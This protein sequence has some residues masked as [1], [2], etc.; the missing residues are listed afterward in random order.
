M[1]LDC[2][3]QHEDLHDHGK[4]TNTCK[5]VAEGQGVGHPT[6]HAAD[7]RQ[8]TVEHIAAAL[9]INL[10]LKCLDQR[11]DVCFVEAC[12]VLV[13]DLVT[14]VNSVVCRLDDVLCRLKV[15]ALVYGGID[16]AVVKALDRHVVSARCRYQ[17]LTGIEIGVVCRDHHL[18][19][20][21]QLIRLKACA[22][23]GN[24]SGSECQRGFPG[25]AA[26]ACQQSDQQQANGH[27]QDDASRKC[28]HF[29]F[30][31]I[32]LAVKPPNLPSL[33]WD[34]APP[35]SVF[36]ARCRGIR[37]CSMEVSSG[38]SPYSSG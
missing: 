35:L 5:V 26:T 24:Q 32:V 25:S 16:L 18:C 11:V 15:H 28:S 20:R 29:R 2:K 36:A 7:A 21:K 34:F 30:H 6:Q 3:G 22:L 14:V 23:L 37:H 38:S 1:L 10:D 13:S 27:H 19:D 8:D 4:Q 31:A 17:H 33:Y 12:L 9:K